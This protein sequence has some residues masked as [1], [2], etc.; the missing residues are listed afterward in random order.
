[1]IHFIQKENNASVRDASVSL[2][3]TFK[4]LLPNEQSIDQAINTL[5]KYRIA[6]INKNALERAETFKMPTPVA[7]TKTTA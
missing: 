3:T 7:S 1:M 5:P 2:L 6:E 4:M